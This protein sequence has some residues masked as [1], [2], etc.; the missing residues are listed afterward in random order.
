[1][2][3]MALHNIP[4]ATV[5]HLTSLFRDIFPDSSIAKEYS[6]SLNKSTCTSVLNGAIAPL[7]QSTYLP[8][9]YF[10]VT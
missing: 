3:F 7:F 10:I 2:H 4:L 9:I 5:D 1:M 6:S 8:V